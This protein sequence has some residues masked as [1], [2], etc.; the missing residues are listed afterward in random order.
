[1]N[2]WII[3]IIILFFVIRSVIKANEQV[4]KNQNAQIPEEQNVNPEKEI[5]WEDIFMPQEKKQPQPIPILSEEKKR[6]KEIKKE[7][8]EE[9][10]NAKE[11]EMVPN[12]DYD[13]EENS[14]GWFKDTEDLQR[15][16]INSEVL[17][18]K[19]QI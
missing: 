11:I 9:V 12:L 3:L 14:S 6:K 8:P 18:R 1:M 10:A 16:V 4:K 13:N 5:T 17:S 19:F 7:I 15:A 2:L